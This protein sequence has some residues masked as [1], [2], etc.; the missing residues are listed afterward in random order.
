MSKDISTDDIN[1][2][3]LNQ[4]LSKIKEK[5][6]NNNQS[7]PG[8]KLQEYYDRNN[9][10]WK[11]PASMEK[12]LK[13]FEVTNE[14]DFRNF[15]IFLPKIRI[16][17]NTQARSTFSQQTTTREDRIKGSSSLIVSTE[18]S[19]KNS[20]Y[21]YKKLGRLNT[22]NKDYT[23]YENKYFEFTYNDVPDKM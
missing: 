22:F 9:T 4:K 5:L 11:R 2:K 8:S 19:I 15:N 6:T 17:H 16:S 18:N 1:Q 7:Q 23:D 13:F 3:S 10:L 12:S 21:K 14:E 20:D